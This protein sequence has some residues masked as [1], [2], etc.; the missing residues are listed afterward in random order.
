MKK[1]FL[2]FLISLIS[3]TVGAETLVQEKLIEFYSTAKKDKPIGTLKLEEYKDHVLAIFEGTGLKKGKYR[4][5]KLEKCTRAAIIKWKAADAPS[6]LL[7]FETNFGEISTD[8]KLVETK[9]SE[10]ELEKFQLGL[11][12]V[13]KSIFAVLSCGI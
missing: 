8:K 5:V 2:L 10:L 12:H 3:P 1:V 7:N 4:I 11:L 9:I 13:E 6:E